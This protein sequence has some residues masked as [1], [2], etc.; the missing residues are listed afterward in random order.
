MHDTHRE[1]FSLVAVQERERPFTGQFGG[2]T[3]DNLNIA[4]RQTGVGVIVTQRV[5]VSIQ[6]NVV[7]FGQV[8][9]SNL[10][11]CTGNLAHTVVCGGVPLNLLPRAANTQV[12]DKGERGPTRGVGPVTVVAQ[13]GEVGGFGEVTEQAAKDGERNGGIL[14][15]VV[16]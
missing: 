9:P 8:V 2:H 14:D 7:L 10:L 6:D 4:R 15:A 1:G 12:L 5:A 3:S 11:V 13:T 16:K